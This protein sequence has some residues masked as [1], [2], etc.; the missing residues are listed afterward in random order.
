MDSYLRF[1]EQHVFPDGNDDADSNTMLPQEYFDAV[2]GSLESEVQMYQDRQHSAVEDDD[3]WSSKVRPCSVLAGAELQ[4]ETDVTNLTHRR[5]VIDLLEIRKAYRAG[6]PRAPR[7]TAVW[8]AKRRNKE[9]DTLILLPR[10]D[11]RKADQ[12]ASNRIPDGCPDSD[13]NRL[14]EAL[15]FAAGADP[16]ALGRAMNSMLRQDAKLP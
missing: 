11:F 14:I 1:V 8:N 13:Q 9:F 7:N 4:G 2:G 12:A 3:E 6:K 15:A 5:M 16:V 10:R